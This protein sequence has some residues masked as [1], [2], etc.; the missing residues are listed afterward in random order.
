MYICYMG[1]SCAAG[2]A[3]MVRTSGLEV[4]WNWVRC[5][6]KCTT[7]RIKS[8]RIAHCAFRSHTIT[9]WYFLF[10]EDTVSGINLVVVG[11]AADQ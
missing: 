2:I 9:A 3:I 6:S 4:V 11:T 5:G 10:V 7:G 8:L 1:H